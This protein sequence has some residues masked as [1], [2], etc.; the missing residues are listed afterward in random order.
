MSDTATSLDDAIRVVVTPSQA[1]Y[2]AGEP[3]SVT[4]TFTN[5]RTPEISSSRSASHSA[6]S[7]HKRGAHSVSSVPL[8]RPPTSPGTRT[9]LP[10]APT[11]NTTVGSV[12]TRKGLIGRGRP[13]KGADDLPEAEARRKQLTKSLSLSLSPTELAA[14]LKGDLNGKSPLRSIIASESQNTSPTSPRVPSPL[15]RSATLP[16]APTHPHARKQSVL[17]GQLQLQ[18]LKPPVSLSPFSPTP[19]ASTSSFSISLDPIA[20]GANSPIPSTPAI[21]SPRPDTSAATIR[22]Q[23]PTVN[24]TSNPSGPV[25][26]AHSHAYPPAPSRA[27]GRGAAQ[28]GHGRPPSS[29]SHG[30]PPRTA[31]SSSFPIPNTELIL[32]SYAQLLGTVSVVPLPGMTTTPEQARTLH[33]LRASLLKRQVVGGGS[34]NITSSLSSQSVGSSAVAPPGPSRRASHTRS[35]SLS[36]G[37]L[38]LLSPAPAPQPWTP[39]HRART[40]SVFSLFSTSSSA[41]SGVGLG[42]GMGVAEEEIDPETPLPTFEIQPAMLAVDL[43]L[44]PGESRSYTYNIVL[45]ETLPPTY[46]G[47]T[48]R[49][50]Y[51][52]V[53][54]ICRA[55]SGPASGGASAAGA[56]SSSRVMKV[57]IRIYNNVSVGKPPSPY[58]LLWPLSSWKTK[59]AQPSATVL[60]NAPQKKDHTI[61]AAGMQA[62]GSGTY[63]DLRA[64][65]RALLASFPDPASKGSVAFRLPIEAVGGGPGH[66]DLERDREREE[67]GG[68]RQAVELLTRNPKKASYDVN[69]DG[70]KVAV[71]TFTKS[72]YRL[73]ETVLGVVEL[74]ERASRARVLKLSAMLEAHESLPGSI[75]SNANARNTR[76]VHAEHHSSFMPSVLRT[77]FSL[78]IPSDASPNF[79]VDVPDPA[80]LGKRTSPGGLEWK[81][82]LCLL[83]SAASPTACEG[84]DGVRLRHLVR[85]GPKG[86]W[87]TSWTATRTIAPQERPDLRKSA[88]PADEPPPTPSTAKSWMSFFATSILT[89]SNID[90]HDGDEELEEELVVD[91]DDAMGAEEEWRDVRAEMVECEVPIR[92]WPGNTAF[93]A[94]EV[95]FEV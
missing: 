52:F 64:Y 51:Q 93:K 79:Q 21:P 1:S 84:P 48:L 65:A 36:S 18:D 3:F 89:P 40:S 61:S 76:R 39:G 58:D 19:N 94:T 91:D 87:G 50:S 80:G 35:A 54:G 15:A 38:S 46:K 27:I 60:D 43:S 85:D 55:T 73:G 32:Y 49:F 70:V 95:V 5:T 23:I 62:S 2:F 63:D 66:L 88:G 77:T 20:E 53:L 42:L 83:V 13:P 75:A 59:G 4:I 9:A 56:N 41:S 57:P 24:G 81:V 6:A 72:A 7:T 47:R 30:Q 86:E 12:T 71:L 44:G 17:D 37:F 68:C 14:Q 92:V 28:L 78:D 69:K 34:M 74:N 8:A 16:I 45:P 90:Y 26:T 67:A 33:H 10:A 25:K 82:R 22:T 29:T 11:R 31:F